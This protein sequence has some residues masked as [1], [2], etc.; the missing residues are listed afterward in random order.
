MQFSDIQHCDPNLAIAVPKPQNA[1]VS[2]SNR[3]S[4]MTEIRN[5]G[6]YS[7]A[8]L[9]SVEEKQILKYS[10]NQLSNYMKEKKDQQIRK[11]GSQGKQSKIKARVPGGGGFMADLANKLKR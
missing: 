11:Q 2:D 9:K 3:A 5:S 8:S 1:L 7:K 6:G 4:L 10:T